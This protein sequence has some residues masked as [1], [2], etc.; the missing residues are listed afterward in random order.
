M[1]EWSLLPV[2]T[3]ACNVVMGVQF[4]P[5]IIHSISSSFLSVS[6]L[7]DEFL[8][9]GC[10]HCQYPVT[11]GRERLFR[12]FEIRYLFPT[13]NGSLLVCCLDPR[14]LTPVRSCVDSSLPVYVGSLL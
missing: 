8:L 6:Y 14:M 5:Y 10:L 12:G 3:A 13:N 11:D 9:L 4:L 2:D 1:L 7:F